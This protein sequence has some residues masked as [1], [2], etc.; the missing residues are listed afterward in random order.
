MRDRPIEIVLCFDE[1][2]LVP[3]EVSIASALWTARRMKVGVNVMTTALSETAERELARL[4][5]I[6]GAASFRVRRVNLDRF[7]GITST[8]RHIPLETYLNLLMGSVFPDLDRAIYLDADVLVRSDLADLWSMKFVGNVCI[9]SDKAWAH[10]LDYRAS[11]G[12]SAED[13]Y[14]NNGVMLVDLKAWREEGFE[15]RFIAKAQTCGSRLPCMDQ[16][17]LNIVLRGRIGSMSSL[18]NFTS[19]EYATR[20][21]DLRD[22]KIIHFSA[23]PKPWQG[24]ADRRA[25]EWRD[26]ELRVREVLRTGGCPAFAFKAK[27]VM[28]R[29][30]LFVKCLFGGGR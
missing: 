20:R 25:R 4:C 17:V 6:L 14:I 3:A 21:C 11:T 16:D 24:A 26:A 1:R 28:L 9:G 8:N 30:C 23:V 18:W 15:E 27:S 2:V 29:S 10:A 7:A 5:E 12:L 13:V 19:Y 22:A